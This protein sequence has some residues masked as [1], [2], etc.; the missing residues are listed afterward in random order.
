MAFDDGLQAIAVFGFLALVV[1]LRNRK[2]LQMAADR[3][4]LYRNMM[5]QPGGSVE[6]VRDLMR[7]DDERREQKDIDD[8]WSGG[9][10]MVAVGLALALF[11]FFLVGAEKPVYLVGLVPGLVGVVNL[12]HAATL[13]RRRRRK[14]GAPS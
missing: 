4:E 2:E 3:H 11:L 10:V 1:W 5:S 6:A 13:A 7:H 12:L 9:M 14:D 8:A